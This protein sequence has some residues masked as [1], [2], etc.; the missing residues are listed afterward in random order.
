AL[1]D[2]ERRYGVRFALH[3]GIRA[4]T[5]HAITFRD[6]EATVVRA[7]LDG[8]VGDVAEQGAAGWFSLAELATLP[9]SSL[10]A[11]ALGALRRAEAGSDARRRR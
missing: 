4:R 9:T 10:V 6:I 5:R 3:D 7:R 2:A 8:V 1:R 11:K